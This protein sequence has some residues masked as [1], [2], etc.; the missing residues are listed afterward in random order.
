MNPFIEPR[1][2]Y[3]HILERQ[4]RLALLKARLDPHA[5]PTDSIRVQSGSIGSILEDVSIE[6]QETQEEIARFENEY[7]AARIRL[8]K[9]LQQRENLTA[10]LIIEMHDLDLMEWSDIGKKLSLSTRQLQRLRNEEAE[11]LGYPLKE[12]GQENR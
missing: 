6:I 5:K 9:I 10:S 7:A 8:K 3:I 11:R 12:E 1:Y 2:W 4:E